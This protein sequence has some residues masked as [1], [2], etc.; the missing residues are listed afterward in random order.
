LEIG[1]GFFLRHGPA[2]EFL[3]KQLLDI[4]KEKD[5]PKI[6]KKHNILD[7]DTGKDKDDLIV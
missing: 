4:K 2:A 1:E 5:R 3:S 6:A 7:N